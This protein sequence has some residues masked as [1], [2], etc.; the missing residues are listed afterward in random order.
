VVPA[1]LVGERASAIRQYNHQAMQQAIAQLFD[2]P[3]LGNNA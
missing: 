3:D 1:F 2:M